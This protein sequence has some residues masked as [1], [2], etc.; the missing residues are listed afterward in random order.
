MGDFNAVLTEQ[1]RINGTPIYENDTVDFKEFIQDCNMAE[2][3]SV[4]AQFTW[5][6]NTVSSRIDRGVGNAEWMLAYPLLHIVIMAPYFSDHAP[7][8][9][10]LTEQQSKRYRP[11]RFFNFI[12]EHAKFQQSVE[13]GWKSINKGDHMENIWGKLKKFKQEI[14]KINTT[15][16]SGIGDKIKSCR[17]Q[18]MEVQEDLRIQRN[19]NELKQVEKMIRE[20]LEKWVL[21]EE[22]VIKK[23][24]KN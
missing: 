3:R 24:S 18:L 23:K 1:D 13:K 11:F 19:S 5:S 16:Y 8:A 2:L 14:K 9:I 22:S 12:A 6:N 15:Q 7:L 21:I 10:V 4:G 20:K 17:Q